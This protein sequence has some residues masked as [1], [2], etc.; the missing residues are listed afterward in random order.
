VGGGS[1][2]EVELGQPLEQ[3]VLGQVE[4]RIQLYEEDKKR[5]EEE[6]KKLGKKYKELRHQKSLPGIG[7]IHAVRIVARV[8]TPH[9]FSCKGHYLSYCGLIKLDKISG[10]KSYGKKSSRYCR[11]L[12]AV[13]KTSAL[14]AIGGD[15]PLNDYYEYLINEKRYSESQARHA[16]A[17]RIAVLSWGVFKSGKRYQPHER[18]SVTGDRV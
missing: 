17:R 13:Y 3:F 4:K 9:R 12:K 15:N 18:R 5:Y 10:G 2:G 11:E 8:V 7:W 14:A 1:G 6:F 16:V